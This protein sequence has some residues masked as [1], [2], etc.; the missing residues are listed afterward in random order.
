MEEEIQ[1][2]YRFYAPYLVPALLIIAFFG[3][4]GYYGTKDKYDNLSEELNMEKEKV[5]IMTEN[6]NALLNTLYYT[7][8]YVLMDE[9]NCEESNGTC[10]NIYDN[11][12]GIRYII[13]PARIPLENTAFDWQKM[14]FNI[15]T[16]DNTTETI[17]FSNN[18]KMKIKGAVAN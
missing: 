17:D 12:Y 15:T 1:K 7:D 2:Q 10:V 16:I 18:N 6:Q 14:A 8:R 3:I 5:R 11:K 4:V 9:T 13:D